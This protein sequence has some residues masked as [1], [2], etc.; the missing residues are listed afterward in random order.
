MALFTTILIALEWIDVPTHINYFETHVSEISTEI[1][2]FLSFV[3]SKF[4]VLELLSLLYRV[5][6][7]LPSR[8]SFHYR[9]YATVVCRQFLLSLLGPN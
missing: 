4:S 3:S 5:A 1:E 7:F 9:R 6:P 2:E 8:T